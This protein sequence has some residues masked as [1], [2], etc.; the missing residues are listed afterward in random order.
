VVDLFEVVLEEDGTLRIDGNDGRDFSVDPSSESYAGT[1][2]IAPGTLG[3]GPVPLVPPVLSFPPSIAPG[4]AL[5]ITPP[6]FAYDPDLGDPVVSYSADVDASDPTNPVY[7]VQSGDQGQAITIVA[8][9]TQGALSADTVSNAVEVASP[10]VVDL[11]EVVLEEDGTLRID[12]NDGRDFSVDPGSNR[13]SGTYGVAPGAL[14][15]GPIALVPPALSV[16]AGA[17]AGDTVVIT[18]ALFAYDPDLGDPA[19]RYS[20]GVDASDP[21]VPVYV[22][23]PGDLGNSLSV[24]VTAAQGASETASTSNGVA[25]A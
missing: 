22:I 2:S 15:L 4:D 14:G 17:A 19:I 25:L 7:T 18:P 24:T 12:G 16:P 9:A 23:Q 11:F 3:A 8:T 6:L 21:D 20:A 10:P 13:Y 1:Y 5:T